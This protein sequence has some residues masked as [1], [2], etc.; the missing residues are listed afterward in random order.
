LLAKVVQCEGLM[1]SKDT[2]KQL[3]NFA[4]EAEDI[5]YKL[6]GLLKDIGSTRKKL[7]VP[8]PDYVIANNKKLEKAV[9]AYYSGK[10]TVVTKMLHLSC[11]GKTQIS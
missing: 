1:E 7:E 3:A 10:V 2:E 5:L 8:I 11:S 9:S 4:V 6:W